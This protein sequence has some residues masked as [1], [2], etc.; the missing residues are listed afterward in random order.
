MLHYALRRLWQLIPT[1]AVVTLI[2]FLL[3]NVVPGSVVSAAA[4]D[5][6]DPAAVA[7]MR[8][9]FG[10]DRPLWE[11]YLSF[12]GNLALG[13][14]G[15]SFNSQ[16]PVIDLLAPRLWPSLKLA[17]AAMAIA[18]VIG[19]PLGFV[20]GLRPGSWPD[21]IASVIAVSG[22]SVP[23]FWLG[24]LLMYLFSVQ[25]GWL[26]TMGYGDGGWRHILL[27]ALSLGV[28]F[29]ALLAR[30]TR[31]AVIDI[32]HAD[33]I[34]T[35]QAKGLR[36]GVIYGKHVM[37]N[38]GTLILTTAGLQFGAIMGKAVIIEKLFS[39]PGVGSL[40]IDSVFVRDIAVAQACVI[41]MILF[42]LLVSLAVDL[43]Y[44]LIDPRIQYR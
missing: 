3:F 30:T 13:D 7:Q 15:V 42:F 41:V 44:T 8:A 6:L 33:Y 37:R 29:M 36:A 24:L 19:V 20:S 5:H 4:T 2:I 16:Q 23:Q 39:W 27:P 1:V 22:L 32:M 34:R 31:A 21:S 26:P 43:L 25:L 38:A 12:M 11:R 14:F 40:L 10:L 35:A 28:S 9:Q 18:I 17:L